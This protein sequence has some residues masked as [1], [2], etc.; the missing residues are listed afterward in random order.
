[1]ASID[2]RARGARILRPPAGSGTGRLAL[3]TLALAPV[4]GAA[5]L[6]AMLARRRF[7]TS[8]A[9]RR[10]LVQLGLGELVRGRSVEAER[11]G[12]GNTNS[13]IA[14]RLVGDGPAVRLVVK[15]A[16]PLG[17][18]MAW[19]ARHFGANYVYAAA[20]AQARIA[21]EAAAL[22]TLAD[23]GVAVPR[24]L[25]AN[26]ERGLIAVA[27]IDGV[28]AATALH[29]AGAGPLARDIGALLARVHRLG[30]TLADG[31]PGNMLVARATRQLVLFDLE[32]A[33]CTGSSPA[34]RGFDLAYAAALMPADELRGAV[35]A[36]Y[37]PR[38]DDDVAAFA[39]AERHLRRFGW[40]FARER[41]RWTPGG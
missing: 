29:E 2:D 1:M 40:L 12:G 9:A 41:A 6:D 34:R 14:V 31:H 7:A 4:L 30:V 38:P 18:V 39:I 11:L 8:E 10:A 17:T 21:R 16:L 15:K 32:F 5:Y 35:L 26:A 3:A 36:G 33:E 27:W 28:H 25:A 13:V 19:G 22:R 23:G 37:G 24:C 20:S